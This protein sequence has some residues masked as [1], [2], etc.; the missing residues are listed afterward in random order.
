MEGYHQN[1]GYHLLRS[2][3]LSH[4]WALL[5]L[6]LHPK[7]QVLSL[8]CSQMR[9]RGKSFAQALSIRKLVGLGRETRLTQ[10]PSIPI[11][12]LLVSLCKWS[13]LFRKACVCHTVC[14]CVSHSVRVCVFYTQCCLEE[15]DICQTTNLK[16]I[17][18]H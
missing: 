5:T 12:L 13:R 16:A 8:H 1:N 3:A 17:S 2:T 11:P 15:R 18:E 7:T 14:V 9:L 6:F 4:L 10:K